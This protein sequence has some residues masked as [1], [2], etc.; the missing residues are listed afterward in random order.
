MYLSS[1]TSKLKGI[2]LST[3]DELWTNEKRGHLRMPDQIA[4]TKQ[5]FAIDRRYRKGVRSV[6][7]E[8]ARFRSVL[9]LK[10]KNVYQMLPLFYS[11]RTFF[12]D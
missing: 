1:S 11:M 9:Y 6:D 7:L 4:K 8:K 10:V 3:I 12:L 5:L 2:P